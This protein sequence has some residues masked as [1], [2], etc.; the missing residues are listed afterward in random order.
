MIGWITLARITYVLALSRAC[1]HRT[2]FHGTRHAML[3]LRNV[4]R[5]AGTLKM[6]LLFIA[7]L[8][9]PTILLAQQTCPA[10]DVQCQRT[11]ELAMTMT[12]TSQ[13]AAI[14]AVLGAFVGDAAGVTLEFTSI[15]S[16]QQVREAMRMPG[17]GVF[18]VGSGQV[19]DD[20]EL[21]LCMLRVSI[22]YDH[23]D[24]LAPSGVRST[25]WHWQAFE[26]MLLGK[27]FAE[28]YRTFCCG[29][30]V[31]CIVLSPGL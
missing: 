25:L 4:S 8:N 9:T 23:V 27:H 24:R 14:G 26:E 31:T 3:L 5:H 12:A 19:S 30:L 28:A 2:P 20:S 7:L 18:R 13:Q 1:E 17:G 16:D 22:N 11:S 29:G 21:A 15:D 10:S 6:L